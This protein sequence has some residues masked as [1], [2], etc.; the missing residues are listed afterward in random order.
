MYVIWDTENQTVITLKEHI[1]QFETEEE[2][3]NFAQQNVINYE[4]IKL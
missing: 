4:I 1:L 3:I 2:A